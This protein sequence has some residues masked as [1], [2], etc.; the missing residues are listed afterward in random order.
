M[1]SIIKIFVRLSVLF[2]LGYSLLTVTL[3]MLK[4]SGLHQGLVSII[5]LVPFIIVGLI[6]VIFSK[7]KQ[8]RWVR[9]LMGFGAFLCCTWYV[10]LIYY[11]VLL[12]PDS[13]VFGANVWSY[14]PYDL[15]LGVIGGIGFWVMIVNGGGR[16]QI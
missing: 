3:N 16:P 2:A 1:K 14:A 4:D 11:P 15:A 10:W 13:F 6:L 5:A 8:R 12:D 7:R 9:H